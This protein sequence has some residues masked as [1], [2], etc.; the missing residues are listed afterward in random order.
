VS[1]PQLAIEGLD[2][3]LAADLAQGL[4]QVEELLSTHIQ[5]DYPLVEETSRHL[6]L[7]GGKRLRPLLVLLT[8]HLGPE[9][10]SNIFKAAV[11]CE[12][13]HLGTLYHDDVM[14]EAALRRGVTSANYRWGNAVAI[15]TGDYLFAKTSALLAEVGPEAVLLQALTFERLVVGQIQETQGPLESEDPMAHYMKVVAN[16]TASLISTSARFG[17]MLSGADPRIT[18]TVTEFGEL[19]GIA[20]QLADDILDIASESAQSGKTP[21]TD[22]KEGI[23]TLVT[24]LAGQSDDPADRDLKEILSKPIHDD[25]LLQQTLARL[26]GHKA[27]DQAREMLAETAARAVRLLDDLPENSVKQALLGVISAVIHRSA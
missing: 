4:A 17:A 1:N 15:L 16:K 3:L 25:A 10:G 8:S 13:T 9:R 23:P 24:I 21:G 19:I 7:A 11:A 6:V 12:L 5:G 14:D 22:L 18:E 26:R 2:P 20:F 27:M